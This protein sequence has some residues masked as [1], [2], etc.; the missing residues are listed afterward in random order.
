VASGLA[1]GFWQLALGPLAVKEMIVLLLTG[2]AVFPFY[3]VPVLVGALL[4]GMVLS[5]LPALRIPLLLV[6]LVTG[7]LSETRVL[8]LPPFWEWRSPLRWWGYF[9]SGWTVAA[10]IGTIS[11]VSP[12][13]RRRMAAGVVAMLGAIVWAARGYGAEWRWT[14]GV[15][16]YLSIY[17][18]IG[19]LFLLSFDWREHHAVRWLSEATYPIYLYHYSIMFLY[20]YFMAGP[21]ERR[22]GLPSVAIETGAFI[23]GGVGSWCVAYYGRRFFGRWARLVLG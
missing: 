2:S 20:T 3:F 11:R 17:C 12:A 9:L 21:L 23:V 4:L 18:C 5:R 8:V 6:L 14:L 22:V 13:V 10:Q 7:L 15:L 16:Q 1:I 19:A